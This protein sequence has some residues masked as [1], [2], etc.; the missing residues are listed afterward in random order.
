MTKGIV[1][2]ACHETSYTLWQHL[3]GRRILHWYDI[4]LLVIGVI[5]L[6]HLYY[7]MY[8]VLTWRQLPPTRQ[9]RAKS[10]LS[11]IC[12]EYCTWSENLTSFFSFFRICRWC[13]QVEF[14][15][16]DAVRRLLYIK[17]LW[18]S[19][20]V[21]CHVCCVYE[22]CIRRQ[23]AW[24]FRNQTQQWIQNDGRAVQQQ[25]TPEDGRPRLL[26]TFSNCP[27]PVMHLTR[28]DGSKQHSKWIPSNLHCWNYCYMCLWKWLWWKKVS[29]KATFVRN[30]F[31]F[32]CLVLGPFLARRRRK[33]L[34]H[35]DSKYC[36]K[37]TCKLDQYW[38]IFYYRDSVSIIWRGE[39]CTQRCR[40]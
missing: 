9:W 40:T 34:C 7:R 30:V 4:F 24:F 20:I 23:L 25:F 2:L 14:V 38:N 17:M 26:F 39:T 32:D 16:W 8:S 28:Y 35:L 15:G 31:Q 27:N 13:R 5:L 19:R 6:R 37:V 22:N 3:L 1:L 33:R 18:W 12:H 29:S 36:T 11:R 10:L 21:G